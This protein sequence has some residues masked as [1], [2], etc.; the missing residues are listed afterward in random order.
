M[1]QELRNLE[2]LFN[3]IAVLA[4]ENGEISLG[5]VVESIGQRSFG[6]LLLI[7]GL[8]LSS[9]LSGIPGM[10]SISAAFIMLIAAQLLLGRR[11]FWLPRWLLDR[12]LEQGQVMKALRWITPFA[13]VIDRMTRPRLFFLVRRS[14]A[15]VTAALC[16]CLAMI[17][18]VFEL[19]PFSASAVGVAL[20]ALGLA[21][22]AQ[23]GLLALIAFSVIGAT[24]GLAV[25]NIL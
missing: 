4:T 25:V 20:A 6:P 3:H 24:F 1:V 12:A 10:T 11:Y 15:Y 14:G 19:V 17:M 22:V 18:P 23:D 21:L 8:T 13:R 16:V 2:Q 5:I 9:P 7:V